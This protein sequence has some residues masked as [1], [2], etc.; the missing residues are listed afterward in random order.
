MKETEELYFLFKYFIHFDIEVFYMRICN[1]YLYIVWLPKNLLTWVFHAFTRN[2]VCRE[3]YPGII[4]YPDIFRLQALVKQTNSP[5]NQ[6]DLKYKG[7]GWLHYYCNF[8][9]TCNENRRL[10]NITAV[11]RWFVFAKSYQLRTCFQTTASALKW[12][13]YVVLKIGFDRLF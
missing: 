6:V 8:C 12:S 7:N 4:S 10:T 3:E 1:Y 9:L 11:L 2:D 5:K 13:K